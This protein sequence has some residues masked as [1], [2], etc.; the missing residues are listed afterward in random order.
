MRVL[1]VDYGSKRIGLAVGDL[2][3]G[4]PRPLATL[5]A[6][7]AIVQDA[8][9]IRTIAASEEARLVVVGLPMQA[10]GTKGPRA[11]VCERLAQALAGAG[12]A[13]AMIDERHSTQ[14][15][16]AAAAGSLDDDAAAAIE[17]WQRYQEAHASP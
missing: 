3:S 8:E 10:D 15:G 1:A 6:K 17:I 14:D 16:S 9:I 11:I 5:A 7:P 12:L 2:E 4:L 13:V